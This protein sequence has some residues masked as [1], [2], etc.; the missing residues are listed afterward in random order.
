MKW[1]NSNLMIDFI[2]RLLLD[3]NSINPFS[4]SLQS[5]QKEKFSRVHS[6]VVPIID[7]SFQVDQLYE[8][9]SVNI[10][11]KKGVSFVC[12]SCHFRSFVFRIL[13][14]LLSM[15]LSSNQFDST[16]GLNYFR[17]GIDNK[18][19]SFISKSIKRTKNMKKERIL[20]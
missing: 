1:V 15:P 9:I 20:S 19:S 13:L 6:K 16:V 17:K 11:K 8:F 12:F 2:I 7:S 10:D 4:L 5:K 3:Y 18:V 14:K